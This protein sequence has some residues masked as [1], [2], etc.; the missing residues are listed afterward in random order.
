MTTLYSVVLQY[1]NNGDWLPSEVVYQSLNQ[2]RAREFFHTHVP[3]ATSI[4]VPETLRN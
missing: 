3:A 2:E 4:Q 1:N